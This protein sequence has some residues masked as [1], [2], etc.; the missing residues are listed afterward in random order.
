M[1]KRQDGDIAGVLSVIGEKPK[2][3][4]YY[5]TGGGPEGVLAAAALDAFGCFFQGKFLFK[6]DL[7]K[8]SFGNIITFEKVKGFS[9]MV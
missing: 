2:N 3:D 8:D 1:F 6:T 9:R 5:S 4:I 7:D